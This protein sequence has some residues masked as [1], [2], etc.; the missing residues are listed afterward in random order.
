MFNKKSNYLTLNP[1]QLWTL[2]SGQYTQDGLTSGPG[3]NN[4]KSDKT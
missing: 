4:A 1:L 3:Q 2:L